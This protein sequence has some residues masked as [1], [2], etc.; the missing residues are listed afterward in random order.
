MNPIDSFRPPSARSP[1]NPL[2]GLLPCVGAGLP[3]SGLGVNLQL[4]C[5]MTLTG[6]IMISLFDSLVISSLN[7]GLVYGISNALNT[8]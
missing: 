4:S 1:A 7:L 8:M 2:V 5:A 3:A 6:W